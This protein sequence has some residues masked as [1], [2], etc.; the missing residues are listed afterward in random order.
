MA[1]APVGSLNA[2]LDRALALLQADP[3]LAERQAGEILKVVPGDPRAV[4][5]FGMARRLRG[6]AAGARAVLEPLAA[7]QPRSAQTHHELGLT[8]AGLGETEGAIG[9]L[10]HAAS[11][12]RDRPETWRALDISRSA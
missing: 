11:L 9:A 4:L 8:L 7:A 1:E 10:R 3:V 12:Q 2:A 6:D 5:I